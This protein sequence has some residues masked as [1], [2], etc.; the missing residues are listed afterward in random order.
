MLGKAVQRVSIWRAPIFSGREFVNPGGDFFG[1]GVSWHFVDDS[2]GLLPGK[3]SSRSLS[4]LGRLA[5]V[6]VDV[7]F[8]TYAAWSAPVAK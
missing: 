3:R 8:G 6:F 2:S 1:R 4:N 7:F 5:F